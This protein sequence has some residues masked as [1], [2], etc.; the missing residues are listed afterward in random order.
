[1]KVT[2]LGVGGSAGL[3]QIGGP[4][5]FGDWG[6]TDP[7]EPRNRRTR[8]SIVIESLEN[9][10][11][12]VDTS[13]DVRLQ[14]TSNG[15]GRID[16]LIYTHAHADHIAGLDEIRILNRLLGAPLPAYTDARTWGE[17]H[18]RFDYAFRPFDGGFFYRPVLDPH[19]VAPGNIVEIQGLPVQFIDQDH[20]TIRSL[21]LRINNFAY[22]TDLVR[23]D[24][25]ALAA[26]EGLDV[27]V[28]DSFTPGPIH[29]THANLATV[30]DWLE[31]LRPKRCILT[32]L[33]P[34]MD[35]QSLRAT[36][37]AGVEP[38]YDGMVIT[39]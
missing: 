15:I 10:R 34:D 22:C 33:G 5:G 4:G 7:S 36:L 16:A 9:K 37:P 28:I 13:P 2:L 23:L 17:L 30:L 26:L 6:K 29:P 21:G 1:M 32:H 20:G 27:L 39:L 35:F 12:L 18:K 25:T 3:P 11:I 38:G 14:L 19:T 24:E 8:S 31:R